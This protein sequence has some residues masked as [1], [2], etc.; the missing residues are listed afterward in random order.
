MSTFH[1]LCCLSMNSQSFKH[2]MS[3]RRIAC[4]RAQGS[5]PN[6]IAKL[7]DCE[8][9]KEATVRQAH[10]HPRLLQHFKA[11]LVVGWKSPPLQT[12][13]EEQEVIPGRRSS[14]GQ[15][16]ERARPDAEQK[17]CF[18]THYYTGMECA[19]LLDGRCFF[20]C[21]IQRLLEVPSSK[22]S[23]LLISWFVGQQGL[24]TPD[25]IPQEPWVWF[26]TITFSTELELGLKFSYSETFVAVHF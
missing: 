8:G 12:A 9:R 4:N 25:H 10:S 6:K 20:K 18:L 17:G 2:Q 21:N 1:P 11:F 15:A 5:F 7:V 22:W 24:F 3:L 26:L 14:V 13:P 23:G 16:R 19:V